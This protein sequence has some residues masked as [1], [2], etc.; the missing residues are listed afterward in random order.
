VT[1]R[2][3]GASHRWLAQ[4]SFVVARVRPELY[5]HLRE[6]CHG[7]ESID[8][9]L[10]RRHA[11]R[12]R[13]GASPDAER[14][15]T[16]RRTWRVDED[17]GVFGFAVIHPGREAR[18]DDPGGADASGAS[19]LSEIVRFLRDV[20]LFRELDDRALAVLAA[21]M[22]EETIPAGATLVREGDW[23]EFFGELSVF[24]RRRRSASVRALTDAVVL[25]LD[26][27]AIPS[28]LD[29]DRD[30]ALR[31]LTV[32]VKEFSRISADGY[33]AVVA[34]SLGTMANPWVRR[35]SAMLRRRRS[36]LR[37]SSELG[38]A[39]RRRSPRRR[40]MTTWTFT[41][42]PK[43]RTAW[44][45]KS[46]RYAEMMQSVGFTVGLPVPRAS[47][48]TRRHACFSKIRT[49]LECERCCG[50]PSAA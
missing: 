23:R 24:S 10:D 17:L 15:R 1:R 22:G 5:D 4:G 14:R 25:T 11:E 18:Q 49:Q 36:R 12:R 37:D 38:T 13:W 39:D 47:R 29:K 31:L 8:V 28:L 45:I 6:G 27:E 34:E 41:T 30:S 3:A 20:P 7:V 42:A 26:R 40:S 21:R 35:R 50:D 48:L 16:E 2:P 32:M 33:V 9:V 43:A 19:S 46:G 44:S